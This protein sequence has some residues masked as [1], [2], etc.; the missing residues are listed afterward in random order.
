MI[1]AKVRTEDPPQVHPVQHN[2]V[3]QALSSDRTDHTLHV[4]VCQGDRAAIITS[5]ALH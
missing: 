5:G 4:W 1:V 2:H 3:V